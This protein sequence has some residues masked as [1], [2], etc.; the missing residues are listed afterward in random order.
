MPT[1]VVLS[2]L[3]QFPNQKKINIL[4]N[5][6]IHPLKSTRIPLNKAQ[7]IV[8]IE[9]EKN[10][11]GSL[12]FTI[13]KDKKILKWIKTD[14]YG[15]ITTCVKWNQNNFFYRDSTHMGTKT[16]NTCLLQKDLVHCKKQESE[17]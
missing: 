14:T 3:I 6:K 5:I 16:N 11:W 12:Y 13:F 9:Y 17:E 4:K 15:A 1:T 10:W 7:K 2:N 8:Y